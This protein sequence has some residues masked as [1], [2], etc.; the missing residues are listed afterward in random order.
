MLLIE[1]TEAGEDVQ[2]AAPVK[3]W[4]VPSANVPVAVKGTPISC[5][6]LVTAGAIDIDASGD[7]ATTK[8][9]V[10]LK[11]PSCAVMVV[12]P[13]D[14]PVACAPFIVATVVSEELQAAI[15]DM[16]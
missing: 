15:D 11:D 8:L 12:V 10:A 6:T 13:A 7:A 1:A 3:T 5:G 4:V 14:C 2:V 16:G 9:A